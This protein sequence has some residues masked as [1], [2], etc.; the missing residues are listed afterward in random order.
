MSRRG[1]LHRLAARASTIDERLSG[2]YL[3]DDAVG[4]NDRAGAEKRLAAWGGPRND[5]DSEWLPRRLARAGI[6]ERA[7]LALLGT[8]K[9]CHS[10]LPAWAKALGW[11]SPAVKWGE[12]RTTKAENAD[13]L[14]FEELLWPAVCAADR[15]LARRLGSA[16]PESLVA[17]ARADLR[18]SLLRRLSRAAGPALFAEFRLFRQ[19]SRAW[20][21]GF[22]AAVGSAGSRVLYDAFVLD[23]RSRWAEFL[24]EKPVLARL[25]GTIV[26]FWL[27]AAVEFIG[28]LTRDYPA[29]CEWLG[30]GIAL[31]KVSA[32]QLDLSDPHRGGRTAL[33]LT[34][35]AGPNL[36]Y[37]P[38]DLRIDAAWAKFLDW[39]DKRGAPVSLKASRV[40]A[41]GDYGWAEFIVKEPDPGPEAGALDRQ[42]G[43]LLALFYLLQARDMHDENVI[44][45]AAGPVVI[46][47]ETLFHPHFAEWLLGRPADG[48]TRAAL[49][50]LADSVLATLYLP[51]WVARPDGRAVAVGGMDKQPQT[52][53]DVG[54]GFRHINTD[55]MTLVR[56]EAELGAASEP[57]GD[58]PPALNIA[59]VT[60]G[61]AAMYSFLAARR[62]E[63]VAPGGPLDEFRGLRV[64]T[65]IAPTPVYGVVAKQ[66]ARPENLGDGADWSLHFESLGRDFPRNLGADGTW[67]VLAAERRDLANLD[68]PFFSAA[69]DARWI[70]TGDGERIEDYLA[71][72]PLETVRR[73][74][75]RL[76]E[77]DLRRQLR[78]IRAALS[79]ARPFHPATG[80]NQTAGHSKAR[81]IARTNPQAKPDEQFVAMAQQ[82][83]ATIA[84]AAIV[85][86]QGAA[87]IG[88]MPVGHDY[89]A[90]DVV[91]TDLYAGTMGIALF[92]AALSHVAEDPGSR[93]LALKAVASARRIHAPFERGARSARRMGIGGGMGIGSVIYGLVR[94]AGFLA[95]PALLEEASRLGMLLTEDRIAADRA[96]GILDGAAGAV[97][98]LLALYRATGDRL[99][100]ERAVLCGRHLLAAQIVD[101]AGNT[102]WRAGRGAVLLNGIAR[103]AAGIA[104]ALA[105]LHAATDETAFLQ[106]A[107]DAVRSERALSAVEAELGGSS[108]RWCDGAAGRHLA[109]LDILTA[110]AAAL[111]RDID[112]ALDAAAG[113]PFSAGDDLCRGNFGRV[114]F[115]LTAG[116]RLRRA[117]LIDQ[118]RR[119]AV[120]LSV[121]AIERGGFALEGAETDLHPGFFRGLSGIGYQLLRLA[122]P[123]KL[124][125]V[126]LW[127]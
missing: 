1:D 16:L 112:F 13:P 99:I 44:P 80:K 20:P 90:V 19:L 64:R 40:L 5:R 52:R 113:A 65:V 115:L 50:Q 49:N 81:E 117:E 62:E 85:D 77:H 60:E 38:K 53:S 87:W 33:I 74:A 61:F 79:I 66:A 105:R 124:P 76:S 41:R 32:L 11:V 54:A 73:R 120:S 30:G 118:A 63:L 91:G 109:Y 55:A 28:G 111:L 75:E 121:R 106:A 86:A 10:P 18:R 110:P 103:G 57:S 8:V 27:E 71:E 31:G 89:A 15:R 35:A 68:I 72:A 58:V 123:A 43:A 45:S 25:I 6:D 34:F 2:D 39:L 88:A 126:L 26:H 22:P 82:I 92:L 42:A 29:L 3:P 94:I 67:R 56:T 7:A 51:V 107:E 98:G 9:P 36:V 83:G 122:A 127:E 21:A 37:K 47:L 101:D 125:S 24:D 116:Q 78:L 93:A 17:S 119:L 70:E 114:E 97:L 102:G 12:G 23:L 48:A 69:T 4:A 46:D 14:P 96:Y 104:L 59:A 84:R 100:L 95:E 108:C